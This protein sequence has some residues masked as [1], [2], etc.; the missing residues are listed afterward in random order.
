MYMHVYIYTIDI[1]LYVCYNSVR[2]LVP[3]MVL[4]FDI[5]AFLVSVYTVTI[6]L[7]WFSQVE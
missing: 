2:L 5:V 6:F 7:R 4:Q 1:T 3:A